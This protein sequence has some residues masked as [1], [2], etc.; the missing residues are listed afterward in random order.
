MDDQACRTIGESA[1]EQGLAYIKRL[2]DLAKAIGRAKFTAPLEPDF[3]WG[4]TSATLAEGGVEPEIL[5]K[6]GVARTLADYAAGRYTGA[7]AG[8]ISFQ[9]Y[10]TTMGVYFL[11]RE[12]DV[13][14]RFTAA[15][16]KALDEMLGEIER[17]SKARD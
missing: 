10:Y 1:A 8:P 16:E 12:A 13:A 4:Y 6:L 3:D 7:Q 14:K 17:R 9:R 11:R 5:A 2:P 15:W